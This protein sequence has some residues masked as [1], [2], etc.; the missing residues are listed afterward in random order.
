MVSLL[1]DLRQGL[2]EAID[3]EKGICP[4]KLSDLRKEWIHPWLSDII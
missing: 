3:Y 2:E 1:D 4:G